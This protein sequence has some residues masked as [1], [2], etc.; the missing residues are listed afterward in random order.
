MRLKVNKTQIVKERGSVRVNGWSPGRAGLSFYF[1][2]PPGLIRLLINGL[3]DLSVFQ[4]KR[5]GRALTT[6]N[7]RNNQQKEP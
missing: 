3:A 5:P 6:N 7:L 2:S 4:A 1:V